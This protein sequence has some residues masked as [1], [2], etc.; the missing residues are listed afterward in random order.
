MD[1]S[2]IQ[3]RKSP[4][5]YNGLVCKALLSSKT[6]KFDGILTS[7]SRKRIS[8]S[9]QLSKGLTLSMLAILSTMQKLVN[10]CQIQTFW[11]F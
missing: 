1:S 2:N 10:E 3:G 6:H 5:D 11:N 7:I 9:A 8:C 4:P